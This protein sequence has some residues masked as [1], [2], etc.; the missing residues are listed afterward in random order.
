MINLKLKVSKSS[1]EEKLNKLKDLANRLDQK[2]NVFEQ[3][4]NNTSKF[5][6]ESDDEY[7]ALIDNANENIAACRKAR[8]KVEESIKMVAN[9]LND[10]E[11]FGKYAGE[12]LRNASEVAKDTIA[13]AA[14]VVTTQLNSVLS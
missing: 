12:T 8:E 11:E 14:D 10:M 9:T 2:I 5:I 13:T 4:K 1:Y 3:Y 7:D 6:E